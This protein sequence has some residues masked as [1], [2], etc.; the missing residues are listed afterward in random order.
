MAEDIEL[1]PAEDSRLN[2]S[3]GRHLTVEHRSIPE[4]HP[5]HWHSY[6]EIEI[7]TSGNGSVTVNDT[8]HD[9]SESNV[10]F[11]TP[12]DFHL[13]NSDGDSTLINV[14]FDEEALNDTELVALI[15]SQKKRAYHPDSE[16]LKRIITACELLKYELDSNGACK[17]EL[18]KYIIRSIFTGAEFSGVSTDEH[19]RGIKKAIMYMEM[20]FKENI[21]LTALANEAG[22]NPAYFSELFKR[23]TGES[24]IESL[25]KLRVGYA[26]S[27]LTNGYSV[28]DASFTSGFRS[29]SNFGSIFKKHCGVSPRE[30]KTAKSVKEQSQ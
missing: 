28:S 16:H 9:F 27:L 11:L 26:R 7:I 23:L 30:Y 15:F 5:R 20:H 24:Y 29:L 10:F 3:Q 1:F 8:L 17:R 18:L 6:F 19:L 22:Y 4:Y 12:T 21:T 25:N 13:I 2:I 14:S